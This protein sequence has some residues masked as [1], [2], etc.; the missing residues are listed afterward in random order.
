MEAWG[1]CR[2]FLNFYIMQKL[3]LIAVLTAFFA[4]GTALDAH[5]RDTEK[6]ARQGQVSIG[7]SDGTKP[8]HDFNDYGLLCAE[9]QGREGAIGPKMH[10]Y[11]RKI[12]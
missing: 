2:T 4:C 10:C 11:C 5:A 7:V 9:F 3:S 1:K 8:W 6:T 12:L